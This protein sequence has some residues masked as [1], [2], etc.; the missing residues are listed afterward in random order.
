MTS[1]VSPFQRGPFGWTTFS[2]DSWQQYA[3]TGC[4]G[5]DIPPWTP[6]CGQYGIPYI[7]PINGTV[8]EDQR[9]YADM[10]GMTMKD[11]LFCVALY[12]HF[13]TKINHPNSPQLVFKVVAF[14]SFPA[15]R[16]VQ[17]CT[18]LG[19]I[20]YH[21]ASSLSAENEFDDRKT[22]DS[23]DG[24]AEAHVETS[25]EVRNATKRRK[26][27]AVEA[28]PDIGTPL[29]RVA[30]H[31]EESEDSGTEHT[32]DGFVVYCLAAL[33]GVHAETKDG[34]SGSRRSPSS[35]STLKRSRPSARL[36]RGDNMF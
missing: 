10:V 31:E 21:G 22:V 7:P 28:E 5:A 24:S 34:G 27:P 26:K 35:H 16:F 23:E 18:A 15:L 32:K 36:K 4:Y 9:S 33:C 1:D 20:V 25:S 3:K 12:G 19:T 6:N 11:L 29:S 17:A 2:P 14:L 8:F 13:H 30:H